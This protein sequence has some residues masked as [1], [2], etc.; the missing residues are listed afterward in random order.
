[1]YHRRPSFLL[2]IN[3]NNNSW[4]SLQ[5]WWKSKMVKKKKIL[6]SALVIYINIFIQFDPRDLLTIY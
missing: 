1:M 6:G 4:D 5:C 2:E 3:K